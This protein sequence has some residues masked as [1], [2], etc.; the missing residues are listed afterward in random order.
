[1]RK[2]LSKMRWRTTHQSR[3]G[4]PMRVTTLELRVTR[5]FAGQIPVE[6]LMNCTS[7]VRRIVPAIGLQEPQPDQLI[8][9]ARPQLDGVASQA[10]TKTPTVTAHALR[11]R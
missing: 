7:H 4:E 10:V 6:E 1:L 8:D 9:L 5:P 11:G 2:L 3:G